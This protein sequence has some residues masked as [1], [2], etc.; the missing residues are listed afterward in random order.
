MGAAQHAF[1]S[2]ELKL[3]SFCL[4]AFFLSTQLSGLHLTTICLRP[5]HTAGAS[6]PLCASWSQHSNSD[7]PSTV[8]KRRGASIQ[9]F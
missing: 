6:I 8:E 9:L 3:S 7:E 2:K 5:V 4:S 1:L